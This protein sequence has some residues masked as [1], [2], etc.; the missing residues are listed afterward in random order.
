MPENSTQGFSSEA[1]SQKA[2]QQPSRKINWLHVLIG[3]VIGLILIGAGFGAYLLT[4]LQQNKESNQPQITTKR[5][6]P[7]AKQA[8]NSAKKDET[9]DWK[10]FINSSY[11][12]SLKYPGILKTYSNS[13][14]GG[15]T[16]ETSGNV[17]FT[18]D[19]KVSSDTVG[20]EGSIGKDFYLLQIYLINKNENSYYSGK[21]LNEIAQADYD[22]NKSSAAS[23][24]P[25]TQTTLG[26]QAAFTYQKTNAS[27][28]DYL[29]GGWV[30]SAE[31]IKIIEVENGSL[32]FY[33]IFRPNEIIEQMLATFKFLP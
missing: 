21:N 18:N 10:T 4:H 22:K 11:K 23:I 16:A 26:G 20:V 12:Y 27:A 13:A 7:S 31:T 29:A 15:D 33:V 8:T 5:S 17:I 19:P 1:L 32:F 24:S 2:T 14:M 30:L 6:T 3:V 9:A 28:F 25:L